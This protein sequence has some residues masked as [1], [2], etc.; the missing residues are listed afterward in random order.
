MDTGGDAVIAEAGQ[1]DAMAGGEIGRDH[2][3]CRARLQL[4]GWT[5]MQHGVLKRSN[6]ANWSSLRTDQSSP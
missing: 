6:S 2:R 5:R 1:V 4:R 3:L